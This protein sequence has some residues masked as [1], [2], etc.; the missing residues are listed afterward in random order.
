MGESDVYIGIDVSQSQL[1]VSSSV[2]DEV[3]CY[4]NDDQGHQ[5]LIGQ[6]QGL[7]CQR[8][9]L[10]AS[11]GYETVVAGELHQAQLPVVIVNARRVRDYAKAKGILAKTDRIDAR[12]LADFAQAIKPEVRPFPTKEAQNL[13]EL[14]V[15]R[16]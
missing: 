8:I 14:V 15:R 3:W 4:G 5:G 9:V 10:E 12:V 2:S 13:S 7:C 1:D 11:G 6:L 16:R